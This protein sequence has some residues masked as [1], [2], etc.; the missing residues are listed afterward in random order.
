MTNTAAA[1][2]LEDKYYNCFPNGCQLRR[3]A[4][5]SR[6][7][8][9]PPPS[10]SKLPLTR[11]ILTSRMLQTH[12]P[13]PCCTLIVGVGPANTTLY[14]LTSGLMTVKK[15]RRLH[16]CGTEKVHTKCSLR[17]PNER[18]Y[19]AAVLRKETVNTH[20]LQIMWSNVG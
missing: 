17:T 20:Y 4:T 15:E 10:K 5:H 7:S 9:Q 8:N 16:Q 19:C 11:I 12:Q 6:R 2:S 18:K 3:L 13:I 1:L 14:F